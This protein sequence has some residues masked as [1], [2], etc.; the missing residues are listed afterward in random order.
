LTVLLDVRAADRLRGKDGSLT[1]LIDALLRTTV[2]DTS[3]DLTRLRIV[4][5]WIQYKSNFRETVDVRAIVGGISPDALEIAVDLRRGLAQ[6]DGLGTA[7]AT[8]LERYKTGATGRVYLEPWCQTSKSCIW[9]FNTLYWKELGLWEEVSGQGYERA[10]PGGESDARNSAAARES[11]LELF[12][13]W[14]HLA[15]RRALPDQLHVLELGV[16]N[17]NQARVWLDEFGRVDRELGREYYR[18][19]HYLLGDY[20]P[21]LLEMARRN[22]GAHADHVS[23]LVLDAL[24]PTKT[25]GFLKYKAFFVYISNV[26]DN[27]PSDE[28][29]RIDGRLFQVEARAYLDGAAAAP[30]AA[31]IGAGPAELAELIRRLL[32]LGPTLLAE[33]FAARFPSPLAAVRFWRDVWERVQLEERYTPVIPSETLAP[34]P[35]VGSEIMRSVVEAHGDIRMHVSNGAATSFIDTLPLLHPHGVLQCHDI[36]VTDTEQYANAFRGPGKYDGSVVNWV[37]GPVLAA[38]GGRHGFEVTFQPFRHRSGSNIMTMLA[39]V[40]E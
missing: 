36:F 10:L 24:Q 25:L 30:I 29:A 2:E 37:N 15:E 6:S 16:G 21:H 13:T 1:A 33:T 17:G 28:I 12:A 14:D 39:R 32:R 11:I 8:A 18:R 7:I 27:L 4:C 26:Y 31:E 38:F 19:L 23:A 9:D 3:I 5:D 34:S 40:R 20:S 35:G 22:V